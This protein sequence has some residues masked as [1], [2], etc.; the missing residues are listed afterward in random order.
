MTKTEMLNLYN[1]FSAAVYYIIGFIFDGN[2]YR[3]NLSHIPE[4]VIRMS[5]QSSRRGAHAQLRLRLNDKQKAEW[6]ASGLASLI[7][8]ADLIENRKQKNRGDRFEEIICNAYG[9]EWVKNSTPFN[10]A[11]DI[12]IDGDEVQIK[13]EEAEITNEKVLASV[14]A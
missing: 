3:I 10:V 2:L 5:K 12:T 9:Q 14:L 4:N 6:I 13:F 7:G 11:G 8:T 1:L